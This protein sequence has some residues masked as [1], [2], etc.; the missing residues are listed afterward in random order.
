MHKGNDLYTGTTTDS[1]IGKHQGIDVFA[2]ILQKIILGD[3]GYTACGTVH[4]PFTGPQIHPARLKRGQTLAEYKKLAHEKKVYN[5]IHSHW[6]G[7]VEHFLAVH[8]WD[9][10]RHSK[11][12][13]G[14][15]I[16]CTMQS[17]VQ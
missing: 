3:G 5:T 13:G 7:R 14:I 1:M 2:D 16:S 4:I 11:T 9:D 8:T 12:G 17:H 15:S 10:S 6:R